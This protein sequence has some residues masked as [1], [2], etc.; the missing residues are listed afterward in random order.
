MEAPP[1]QAPTTAA[2]LYHASFHIP[3]HPDADTTRFLFLTPT[4][5]I[6]F[7]WTGDD[8]SL[9]PDMAH[10]PHQ[11]TTFILNWKQ[12]VFNYLDDKCPN[13]LQI[14]SY[15]QEGNELNKQRRRPSPTMYWE[16]ASLSPP[17]PPP[18]CC[19]P[20]LIQQGE[21]DNK[22]TWASA[23]DGLI[24]PHPF[25][26]SLAFLFLPFLTLPIILGDLPSPKFQRQNKNHPKS[27]QRENHVS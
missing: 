27:L 7:T 8:A 2:A 14:Q 21:A 9:S 3:R 20:V 26:F 10:H 17:P 1:H 5:H 6:F 13:T 22:T 19:C 11:G 15:G 18:Y 12:H 23:P 16:Q 4:Q 24:L 25:S